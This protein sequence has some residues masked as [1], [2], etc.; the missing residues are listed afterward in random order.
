MATRPEATQQQMTTSAYSEH[1]SSTSHGELK[2]VTNVCDGNTFCECT[3][4]TSG[5]IHNLQR[6]LVETLVMDYLN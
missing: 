2:K 5:E 1:P 6:V 3:S 4:N